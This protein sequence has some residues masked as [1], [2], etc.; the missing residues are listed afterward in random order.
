MKKLTLLFILAGLLSTINLYASHTAD[1]KRVRDSIFLRANSI[2]VD[3]LRSQFL[4]EAFEQYIDKE[5]ST[6]Y[7]DSAIA[8]SIRKGLHNEELWSLF[9]YCRF[10]AYRT[11]IIMMQKSLVPLKEA[12]YRYKEYSYYYTIWLDLLQSRCA[13]GDTEYVILQAKEMRKEAIRLKYKGGELIALLALAQAYDFNGN[14]EEAISTYKQSLTE[15]PNANNEALLLIHGN[16]AELYKKQ[17]KYQP[18]LNELQLQ[19]DALTR[20]DQGSQ[21]PTILKGLFLGVEIAICKIYLETNDK[22]NLNLHLKKAAEYYDKN[23]YPNAYIDYHALWASYYKQIKQWD[24]CFYEYSLS[25]SACKGIEPFKEN[26]IL[27]KYADALLE[28]GKYEEAS[29]TYKKAI[30]RDDSLKQD[31]LQRHQ[32]AHQGNFKI[33]SALLEKEQL[34]KRHLYI[35]AGAGVAILMTFILSIIRAIFIHRQLKKSEN[36]TRLALKEVE[37]ADKMKDC[38]L[39]NITHEIRIPLN[40]V[41]GFAELLS[42]ES[43]LTEEE[44]AEYSTVIKK[45]STKLLSLINNILDLSRLEAGMMRFNVQENDVVQL[46]R[47]AKMMVEMATPHIVKPMFSTELEELSFNIDSKWFLKLLT[48]LLS[49]SLD[50]NGE[51]Y[52]IEYELTRQNGTINI[53]VKNSPLY[54]CWEDEQEQNMLH[55]INRLYVETFKGSYQVQE[56]EGMKLVSTTYPIS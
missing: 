47:E 2:K 42:S 52:T 27:K 21:L 17:K 9:N 20:L 25:L 29:K 40:T 16:M 14:I 38:F 4:R 7:L 22:E 41:V 51:P 6:E 33:K 15:N 18:A 55:N 43:E 24:K 13:L 49:V 37:A 28:A 19:H 50:Y 35:Q 48:T 39:H 44:S 12:S 46:C 54:Q 30:I 1:E 36:K 56:K 45:N 11:D 8:L 10:Y 34:T 31:M 53:L 3:S 5:S 32:E 26:G 23:T